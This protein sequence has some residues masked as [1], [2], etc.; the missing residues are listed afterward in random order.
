MNKIDLKRLTSI[1]EDFALWAVEQAALIRSGRFDRL[2]SEN[3]AEEL[4]SLGRGDKYQIDH[5]M[6]VLLAHLL[7]WQH[8]AAKR[9]FAGKRR[10][11]SSG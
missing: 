5:R 10:L 1:D 4:E 2:D 8:Q 3:L 9:K 11:P 6:E 7:K